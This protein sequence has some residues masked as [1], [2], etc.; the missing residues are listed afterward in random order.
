L[1]AQR[2]LIVGLVF[3]I[4]STVALA[5]AI[6]AARQIRQPYPVYV[7][8]AAAGIV[9]GEPF[10]DVLGHFAFP[11][12]GVT[13]Y[14]HALGRTVPLYFAP[15][16]FFYFGGGVLVTMRLIQKGVTGRG[17][18][19]W[20]AAATAFALAIEPPF[21]YFGAWTYYGPNQPLMFFGLPLWWGFAN[22]ASWLVT[23]SILHLL[24]TRRVLTG[25]GTLAVLPL[26][27]LIFIGADT[28]M[29]LPAYLAVNSSH[30][31]LVT[32]AAQ[33]VTI[34]VAVWAVWA[35]G[36]LHL[37]DGTAQAHTSAPSASHVSA[38]RS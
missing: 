18:W 21:I 15:A 17:W 16:Y 25:A 27:P 2:Q 3:T 9:F 31:L 8:L 33:L 26:L 11:E 5:Y 37:P 24:I 19:R 20:Y 35:C 34:A 23:G 28:M 12:L 1:S 10:V 14:L 7:V 30:S 22:T 29:T 4:A 32:N 13:P 6:R 38:R 36:K